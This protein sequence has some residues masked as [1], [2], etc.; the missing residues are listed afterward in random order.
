VVPGLDIA[1][2]VNSEPY[3]SKETI[4]TLK[5]DLQDIAG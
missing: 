5:N 3:V 4:E 2:F 1:S